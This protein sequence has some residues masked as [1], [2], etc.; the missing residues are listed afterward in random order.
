MS[1]II[2]PVDENEHAQKLQKELFIVIVECIFTIIKAT[3]LTCVAFV[4]TQTEATFI[5]VMF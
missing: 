1:I 2:L 4:N 3:N 5:L